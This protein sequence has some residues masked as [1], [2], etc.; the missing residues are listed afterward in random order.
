MNDKVMRWNNASEI[1]ESTYAD[2][3][4]IPVLVSDGILVEFAVWN[5]IT[6]T[7]QSEID[8]KI[9]HEIR[10]WMYPQQ[11]FSPKQ[12]MQLS[13]IKTPWDKQ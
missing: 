5:K 13:G 9:S 4:Y 12:M 1:P 3:D 2:C 11:V 10:Y 7:F 8:A 6:Q